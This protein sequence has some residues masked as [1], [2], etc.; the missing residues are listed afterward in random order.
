[1]PFESTLDLGH[2]ITRID[3]GMVRDEL[4]ACY[5]MQGGNEYALI[6]TGTDRKSVV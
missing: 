2:G 5:L 4:A 1:M 3:S 6:E